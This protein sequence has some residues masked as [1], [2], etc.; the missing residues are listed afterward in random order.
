LESDGKI[1]DKFSIDFKLANQSVLEV[2]K[3]VETG[4]EN[5]D[6]G[7]QINNHGN[8]RTTID[9]FADLANSNDEVK[10]PLDGSENKSALKTQIVARPS[11]VSNFRDMGK[12]QPIADAS[13]PSIAI[14]LKRKMSELGT[15]R[16]T[17]DQCRL[18]CYD[19]YGDTKIGD[20]FWGKVFNGTDHKFM[21]L[22]NIINYLDYASIECPPEV[23]ESFEAKSDERQPVDISGDEDLTDVVSALYALMDIVTLP[24]KQRK[25]EDNCRELLSKKY[26]FNDDTIKKAIV[27]SL[28]CSKDGMIGNEDVHLAI[29]RAKLRQ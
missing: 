22:S 6:D 18:A 21:T 2:G 7:L 27:L 16:L 19:V 23:K 1:I 26:M 4:T 17:K 12:M 20:K 11:V 15:D 8:V 29:E 10:E 24:V 9:R 28:T 13:D 25:S 3:V 14:V 5:H